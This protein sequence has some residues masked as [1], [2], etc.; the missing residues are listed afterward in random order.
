MLYPGANAGEFKSGLAPLQKYITPALRKQ[1]PQ[2]RDAKSPN[3]DVLAVPY[4]SYV[5]TM[6]FNRGLFTKAGLNP[7]QPP[8]TW[9]AFMNAC[10]KLSAAASRRSRPAGR[11]GSS[12]S[13][14]STSWPTSSCRRPI[15]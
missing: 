9:S 7:S 1:V 10:D 11:T 8:K 15:R 3:G 5:Y 4:T 12:S 2:I 13:G 14:T 6:Y